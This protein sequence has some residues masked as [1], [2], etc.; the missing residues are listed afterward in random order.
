MEEL[1]DIELVDDELLLY[2]GDGPVTVTVSIEIV[3]SAGDVLAADVMAPVIV[4]IPLAMVELAGKPFVV[5]LGYAA[6][7]LYP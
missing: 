3:V 5:V 4:L 6:E 2:E 1:E 7:Q